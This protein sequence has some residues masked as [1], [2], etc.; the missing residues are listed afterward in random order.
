MF[1]IGQHKTG[2]KFLQTFLALNSKNLYSHGVC[3]PTAFNYQK[4][5]AYRN[6]H[7]N[8]YA[9]LRKEIIER[10]RVDVKGDFWNE[11]KQYVNGITG[12]SELFGLIDN[13]S[14]KHQAH[15]IV[16]SSE[17]L[18][19]MQ[20]AHKLD[21]SLDCVKWA[22]KRL[23]ECSEQFKWDP[24]IIIYLRRPD[25]LLNA[26]YAQFIKGNSSNTMKFNEFHTKFD[27]RLDALRILEVWESIFGR[28]KIKVRPYNDIPLK[29][30]IVSDFFEHALNLRINKTWTPVPEELEYL[31]ITPDSKYIELIREVNSGSK[32]FAGLVS[33]D[34][35]LRRAFEKRSNH[36]C[37]HILPDALATSLIEQYADDYKLIAENFMLVNQ[38]FSCQWTLQKRLNEQQQDLS[39]LDQFFIALK[40]MRLKFPFLRNS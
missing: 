12:L 20:T 23:L 9:L 17:D 21:F 19:D 5:S 3:Y 35:L 1:H 25:Y 34:D 13:E 15:T 27:Q 4:I 16:L 24:E 36:S 28:G 37:S 26:H 6:S 22:A 11:N 18:F 31:N 32:I 40:S 39:K 29:T 8:L 33:R 10:E 7:F 2:S 30:E 38:F 14:S